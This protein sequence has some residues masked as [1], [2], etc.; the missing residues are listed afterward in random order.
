MHL[1]ALP[2]VRANDPEISK[3]LLRPTLSDRGLQTKPLHRHTQLP[4]QILFL[5]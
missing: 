1:G 4:Q 5:G 3:T 2:D